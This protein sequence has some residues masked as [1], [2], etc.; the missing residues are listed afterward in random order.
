MFY[1]SSKAGN[2]WGITDTDDG[3]EELH[4]KEEV[5]DFINL[6]IPISG[7]RKD[8]IFVQS[9]AS[10]FLDKLENGMPVTYTK[11]SSI[12]NSVKLITCIYGGFDIERGYL[13]LDE[14][15]LFAFSN[16][17]LSR[18]KDIVFD[19]KNVDPIMVTKIMRNQR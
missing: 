17:F 16:D 10:R 1:I 5:F 19:N 15:S 12:D 2:K 9:K 8:G 4:T 11:R 6:G 18:N 7:V 3:S 13:F 14:S